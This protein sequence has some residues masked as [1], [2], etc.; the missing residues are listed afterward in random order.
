MKKD[1]FNFVHYINFK[2]L[3]YKI[4]TSYFASI[5]Y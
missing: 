5:L 1:P 2:Q 3:P 4:E